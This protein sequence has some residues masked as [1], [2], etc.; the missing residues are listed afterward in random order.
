MTM[1]ALSI[2]MTIIYMLFSIKACN[3]SDN[4]PVSQTVTGADKSGEGK[5]TIRLLFSQTDTAPKLQGILELYMAQNPDVQIQIQTIGDMGLYRSELSSRFATGKQIDLFMVWGLEDA[6]K[7]QDYMEDL[8]DTP[9]ADCAL[10]GTLSAMTIEQKV[11]G[12]PY[13]AQGYGLIYNRE[14]FEQAGIDLCAAEDF[15]LLEEAFQQLKE[16]IDEGDFAES[17]PLLKSVTE[18]PVKEASIAGDWTVNL[19]LAEDFGSM[20]DAERSK[21]LHL[22]AAEPLRKYYDLMAG[23][24][25]TEK[26]RLEYSDYLA[27]VENGIAVGRVAIIQQSNQIYEDVAGMDDRIAEKL[28]LLPI[29]L[30]GQEKGGV[31]VGVPAYWAVNSKSHDRVKQEAIRFL[32]WL[33]LENGPDAESHSLG[34][35]N[36]YADW[37]DENILDKQVKSAVEQGIAKP[38]IYTGAPDGWNQEFYQGIKEYF[39]ESL[40]WNQLIEQSVQSWREKRSSG[41]H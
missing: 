18:F 6:V 17:Y 27:Q 22:I 2:F 24:S 11:L 30:E 12:L 4:A 3:V 20:Q 23:Y 9:L 8:T 14:I 10:P 32:T 19:A 15:P 39:Q 16:G 38:W 34:V 5:A 7:Y 35:L 37:P 41:S 31:Y 40:T 28:R 26:G 29:C 25:H 1:R 36:P 13:T 21:A 33:Y